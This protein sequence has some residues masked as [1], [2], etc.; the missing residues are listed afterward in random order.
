MASVFLNGELV[1]IEDEMTLGYVLNHWHYNR[2]LIAVA[3][4]ETFISRR[5]Y[6]ETIIRNNDKIEVVSAMQGG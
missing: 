2:E 3:L 4:N 5:L 1:D 6:D